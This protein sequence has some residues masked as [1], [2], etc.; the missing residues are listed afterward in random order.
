[1]GD[2]DASACVTGKSS[3]VGGINGRTESTGLGVY[4]MIRDVCN[5]PNL[6]N[7][8][9]KHGITEG[10]KGKTFITQGFGNV[11]YWVAKFCCND[12][13]KLVG[14]VER[15]GSVYNEN[16]IDPQAL[17]DHITKTGGVQGFTGGKV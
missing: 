6:A 8:R 15:D 4:F 1:M 12:D 5:K 14:V 17:K 7:L 3:S 10:L 11:G 2:I 9:K 13:A 16:G